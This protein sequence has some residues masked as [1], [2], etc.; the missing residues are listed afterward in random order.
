MSVNGNAGGGSCAHPWS[1]PHYGYGNWLSAQCSV[2][3][4]STNNGKIYCNN[5][6]NVSRNCTTARNSQT[7]L[8]APSVYYTNC[9]SLNQEKLA[10]LRQYTVRYDPDVICLTETWFTQEREDNSQIPGYNLFCS[11]RVKRI[12]GGAAIYIRS[13]INAKVIERCDSSTVSAVWLLVRHPEMPKTILSCIYHPPSSD[14]NV[15]LDY[16]ENSLCKLCSK[17]PNAKI[18]VIGDFNK[19]PLEFLCNQFNLKCCIDFCTRGD[20]VLDQIITDIDG[21]TA[22]E[23]L[24]PLIGNEDDHC[25]VYMKSVTVKR[26]QY[27]R[28]RRRKI[29]PASR[30]QVLLDL[31]K[32]D[33]SEVTAAGSV[34]TKAEIFHETVTNILDRHCPY[35]TYKTR[36]DKPN[37]IDPT[38]DKLMNA[39]DRHFKTR[40]RSKSWKFL[41]KLCQKMLRKRIRGYFQTKQQNASSS[42]AWWTVIKEMEGNCQDQQP[43]FH[44]ID[45]TWVTTE[46]LV[47]ILNK[48][49]VRVG[50]DRDAANRP[51]TLFQPLCELSIGEVKQLINKL[52]TSKSTNSDDFPTWVSK[53]AVEDICVPVT[54]II[55]CMLKTNQYP[56]I[57]KHAEIR[58]L[59]KTKNPSTPNHY[60]P[61]SLLFHIGKVAEEVILRKLRIQIEHK[62]ESSQ[63]A[64]QQEKSTTDAL[65]HVIHDWCSE[66][67]KQS[68]SNVTTC[69]IDMS[70]AFDRLDPNILVQKLKTLSVN[71]GL[72]HLIDNFLTNRKCCVK[73]GN[74]CRSSYESIT[75]GAPQG[76]KLGPWFW[77]VYLNDLTIQDLPIVK[78]AD[79]MTLYTPVKKDASNQQLFQAALNTVEE[80][81]SNNN[82]L[83]NADKT[84][85][86]KISL[87]E[88]DLTD[89]YV[90]K[91][92][93]INECDSA[94]LLGITIDSRLSFTQHVKS[95]TESLASRLY[96]MR[97]LKRLGLKAPGLKL[98]YFSNIRSRLT[99]AC[100]A[101]SGFITDNS[102]SEIVKIEKSAMKILNPDIG[103][104][105]S[106]TMYDIPPIEKYIDEQCRKHYHKI[107]SNEEHPLHKNI[108]RNTNRKTRVSAIVKMPRCRTEKLKKS[109]FFKYANCV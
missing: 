22:P 61:I 7:T 79:D 78:Y 63:Y 94:K 6:K 107:I 100:P 10:D 57:W 15:T 8:T 102:M 54:D 20:A 75:M 92:Q 96:A 93:T 62:L 82:M 39:R 44:L 83:I 73:L 95:I 49:F 108:M 72:I 41:S 11:N 38:L 13:S 27:H 64:Y 103:Y 24:P 1:D 29:T 59:K 37:Y 76:T 70:K 106:L 30:Q 42:H 60:R 36:Q 19:M 52:D 104:E 12:G 97:Q 45:D 69:L 58:P 25:A 21:Y 3:Q 40:G 32:Q 101:W 86:I 67:D 50:G 16:L 88:P 99:Y 48:H 56:Q 105:N 34:D 17:N 33:W 51:E 77:L 31:A 18:M 85:L 46:K 81:A 47:T 65:L 43:N 28:I 4:M 2:N 55:N 90:L 80:W 74:T 53:S 35:V 84:Q 71:D 98:F 68:K 14:N 89:S 5:L 91:Q 66:L 23:A 109:F 26:R 9:R 87:T